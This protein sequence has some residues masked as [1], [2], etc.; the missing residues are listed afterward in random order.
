MSSLTQ[1]WIF[2]SIAVGGGVLGKDDGTARGV[3]VPVGGTIEVF[4]LFMDKYPTTG[5]MTIGSIAGKAVNGTIDS[6]LISK[7]NR[8][9]GA[10]KRINIGKSK[11]PGASGV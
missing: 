7:F 9:G 5:G 1:M 11:I 8:I 3:I 4:H 2:S 6:Y 10:G